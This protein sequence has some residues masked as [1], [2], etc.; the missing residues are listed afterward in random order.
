[1]PGALA[2]AV[3]ASGPRHVAGPVADIE[4]GFRGV[5]D[6]G[7]CGEATCRGLGSCTPST[8][9][10]GG[11][12]GG[13]KLGGKAS[14][15]PPIPPP[16]V[17]VGGRPAA[18]PCPKTTAPKF[19]V[20]PVPSSIL[21]S[22]TSMTHADQGRLQDAAAA[23]GSGFGRSPTGR[24]SR[25]RVGRTRLACRRTAPAAP[26]RVPRSLT[27]QGRRRPWQTPRDPC[28]LR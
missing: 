10:C 15:K 24:P 25:A 6:E 20:R 1:M 9:T 19:C 14:P 3:P 27:A 11:K 26:R 18:G 21:A 4:N 17:P 5:D 2:V 13:G 16:G 7:E 12:G 22:V 28:T 8:G 23:G